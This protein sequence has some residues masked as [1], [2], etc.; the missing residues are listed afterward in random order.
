[1]KTWIVDIDGTLALKGERGPFDWHR[2]GEDAPNEP[3]ITVVQALH[4]AGHR[5]VFVSG[6]M[7]CCRD[8]TAAWLDKHLFPVLGMLLMM[9]PDGDYRPDDVLKRE[10]WETKI[11]DRFDVAGVIDDR[12]RVVAMWRS[13]GL[14]CLQVAPG[15]F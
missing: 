5:I 12:A 14:T 8:A 15:D 6:R 4:S 7:E 1:L 2:V 9:R 13:L 10:I 11:R 3:V